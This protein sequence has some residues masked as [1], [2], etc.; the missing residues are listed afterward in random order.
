MEIRVVKNEDGV[1]T[2]EEVV[3]KTVKAADVDEWTARIE[4]NAEQIK[5]LEAENEQLAATVEA[6]K[7]ILDLAQAEAETAE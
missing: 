3:I 5:A 1:V 4:A 6:A 2:Y 7:A